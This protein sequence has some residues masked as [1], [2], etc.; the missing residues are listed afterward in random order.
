MADC[1]RMRELKQKP[2]RKRNKSAGSIDLNYSCAS[3]EKGKS[4]EMIENFLNWNSHASSSKVLIPNSCFFVIAFGLLII[5]H[6]FSSI[7]PFQELKSKHTIQIFQ[8]IC[9][10]NQQT[11]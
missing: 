11:C 1:K 7:V 4:K 8:V 10:F 6:M 5:K 9:I 2:A 3:L